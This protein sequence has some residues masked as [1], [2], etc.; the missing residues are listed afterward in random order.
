[1]VALQL[2]KHTCNVSDEEVSHY[3]WRTLTGNNTSAANNTS[4][5]MRLTL[6]SSLAT[7]FRGS[8][9][10]P[11]VNSFRLDAECRLATKTVASPHWP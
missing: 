11:V 2:L 8:W 9:V 1:M 10:K 6:E 7:G 3:R 4:A 5:T